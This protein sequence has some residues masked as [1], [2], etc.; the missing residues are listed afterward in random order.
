MSLVMLCHADGIVVRSPSGG[1]LGIVNALAALDYDP[2]APANLPL[3]NFVL[4]GESA[5]HSCL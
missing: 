1:V 3:Q 2:A 5:G 4:A